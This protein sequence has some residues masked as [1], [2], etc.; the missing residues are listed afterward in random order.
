LKQC[1]CCD[2]VKFLIFF[3]FRRIQKCTKISLFCFSGK[4]S[5]DQRSSKHGGGRRDG[6]GSGGGSGGFGGGGRVSEK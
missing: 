6:R 1:Y 5:T 2:L 3:A 4:G